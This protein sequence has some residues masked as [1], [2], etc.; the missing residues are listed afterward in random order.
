MLRDV[1][2]VYPGL[3][4]PQADSIRFHAPC[5]HQDIIS[6]LQD[7]LPVLP[8]ALVTIALSAVP[9][10]ALFALPTALLWRKPPYLSHC[11]VFVTGGTRDSL[12]IACLVFQA[13]TKA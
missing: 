11:N 7:P 8:V 12:P 3:T 4:R 1:C 9:N 6:R 2:F 5:A 10:I 13:L